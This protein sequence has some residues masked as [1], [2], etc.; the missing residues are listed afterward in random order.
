[1]TALA[2]WRAG[3]LA[4]LA[5][6]ALL[7]LALA[8]VARDRYARALAARDATAAAAYLTIVT[9][10][11]RRGAAY[12]LPQLLIRARA[13]EELPGFSGRFEV[14]HATA[15]LV[16]AIAPPLPAATL[17]RL[18]RE[19]AVRWTGA[20]ALAPLFDR[21]GW[22]VV[23]AVAAR[24]AVRTWP[25]SP[26]SL[27]A[28]LLF[29]VA[30]T[31]SLRAIGTPRRAW[32]QAVGPY[33]IMA[34]LFGVAVFAD[35]R[36][37]ARDATDRW[38]YDAR[39]LMQEAAAQL[40]E[41]R[42]APASLATIARGAEIVPGDSEPAAAWRRDAG[43][44]RRAAVAVR[45]A[46]GRWLELRVRP[47]ETGSGGWLP[48]MLGL[49]ALGPLGTLFAA[50]S[51]ATAPKRRRETV[52]AWGFLAPS[53]LHLTACSFVPLLFVLYVSL[54][55]WS[56]IEPERPFVGLANYGHAVR[57]P[58][59]W[60]ALGHTLVYALYVP[61][62]MAV[63]LVLAVVL[64]RRGRAG[65][66][67]LRTLF[68]LPYASSVVA[69]ALLWQW[70]YHP[71]FGLINH[72]LTRVRLAPVNW[73]GDRRTALVAVML[74]SVWMQLGYQLTVFLA[75]LRAIPPAYLDAARVDGASAWQRFWRVTFPLLRPVTLF[76]LVTGLIGAFQVFALVMV[77]TGG[78]PLGVTDVIVYRI[79][80]TAWE[81][82]QFGDASALALL[83]FA[84]LFGATWAQLK[85]L[86]RRVEHA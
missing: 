40:P 86:D 65:G 79:Y 38:L 20:A 3:A 13:L 76:V 58:L 71:D 14:Y 82:L 63:A 43:G 78:G 39:L 59:V 60:S 10:L 83:L 4:T 84:L 19:V 47:G 7:P 69:I 67:A 11:A 5:A 54:H 24:P 80:R 28:L 72:V 16:R 26:W 52:A 29:L 48:V 41:I 81:V 27:A 15:P 49:A 50:W 85:L 36:G 18:R 77:L 64:A 8:H 21:D 32:R 42:S 9:P 35:V 70:M 53:V 33:G 1:M 55:R 74:V 51:T 62:S 56:P 30:G 17:Q 22:D 46:P 45:L 37:A 25:L 68:L 66:G 75:G 31:Q 61:V 2:R 34:V 23:G 57:D 6:G 12:D 44:L 73:L